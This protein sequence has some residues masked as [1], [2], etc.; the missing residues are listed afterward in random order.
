[1]K[2]IYKYALNL[3]YQKIGWRLPIPEDSIVRHVGEQSGQICLWIEIDDDYLL[4]KVDNNC[5][6]NEDERIFYI[7]GTGEY[8]HLH[9]NFIGTVQMKNG[10]VWHVYEE[11]R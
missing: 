10:L 4:P 5:L 8:L 11:N 9:L 6:P 1:M 2:T 7:F 3:D